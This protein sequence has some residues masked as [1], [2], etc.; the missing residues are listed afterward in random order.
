MRANELVVGAGGEL[1]K[2]WESV[3]DP[4]EVIGHIS[5]WRDPNDR[6]LKWLTYDPFTD[7]ECRSCPALPVCM[8]GCAHHAMQAKLRDSRCSTFRYTQVEQVDEYVSAAE[9]ANR[10]GVVHAGQLTR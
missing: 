3:G 7:E 10:S 1:Y 4:Q 5:S 6:I 9:R 2:C 8:G